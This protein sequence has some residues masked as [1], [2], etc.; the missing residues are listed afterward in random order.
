M[1]QDQD[2]FRYN[3][4]TFTVYSD[5]NFNNGKLHLI[6]GELNP[7]RDISR[8][9]LIAVPDIP[10]LHTPIIADLRIR[11]MRFGSATP[12]TRLMGNPYFDARPAFQALYYR[13]GHCD[14]I[15]ERIPLWDDVL[16]SV[17]WRTYQNT[18][19][20]TLDHLLND[21][22]LLIQTLLSSYLNRPT[23]ADISEDVW[24]R[25]LH[26]IY[27]LAH[28]ICYAA[29]PD[30]ENLLQRMIKVSKVMGVGYEFKCVVC[31]TQEQLSRSQC[32]YYEKKG[33]NMPKRCATCRGNR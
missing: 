18:P 28:A 6:K 9:D 21:A 12:L 11:F 17:V 8:R 7:K 2:F 19:D 5:F 24:Q 23:N 31:G 33:F 15:I 26:G 22:D 32:R 4:S 30:S 29:N 14:P 25:H 13:L 1:S 20:P 10:F 3:G 27:T 16:E